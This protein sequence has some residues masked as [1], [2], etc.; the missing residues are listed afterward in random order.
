ME[1][2]VIDSTIDMVSDVQNFNYKWVFAQDESQKKELKITMLCET[3]PKFC[4]TINKKLEGKKYI[5][6]ERI[7]IADFFLWGWVSTWF[8]NPESEV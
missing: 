5:C 3:L 7:T 1:A 2:W 4:E 8:T 6:G